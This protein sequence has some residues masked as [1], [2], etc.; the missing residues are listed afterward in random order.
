MPDHVTELSTQERD[1]ALNF[2]EGFWREDRK[3]SGK[4]IDVLRGQNI[5]PNS[6]SIDRTDGLANIVSHKSTDLRLKSYRSPKSVYRLGMRFVRQLASYQG[7]VRADHHK[8]ATYHLHWMTENPN[9]RRTLEWFIPASGVAD[10]QWL[11]LE[12]VVA[13]AA[14]MGVSVVLLKVL[15]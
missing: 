7:E 8:K 9:C 12:R 4:R 2:G 10:E 5:P 11:G 15:D 13:D 1:V 6:V 14:P 3:L